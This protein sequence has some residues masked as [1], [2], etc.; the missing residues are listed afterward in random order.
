MVR[1]SIYNITELQSNCIWFLHTYPLCQLLPKGVQILSYFKQIN[2]EIFTKPKIL[3][4][5]ILN[6][7][8]N[9]EEPISIYNILHVYIHT[10]IYT[11]IK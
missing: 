10:H 9:K 2:L 11:Y 3:F 7:Q 8:T 5:F 4:L 1:P 6:L